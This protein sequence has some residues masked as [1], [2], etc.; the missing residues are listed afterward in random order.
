MLRTLLRTLCGALLA[1]ASLTA[2]HANLVT[3]GG[4][5]DG[6]TGFTSA[7]TY[8]SD[9][10]PEGTYYVGSD[11]HNFHPLFFGL[12]HSGINFM[13]VNGSSTP[14]MRSGGTLLQTRSTRENTM[15][16]SKSFHASCRDRYS[17]CTSS[18][19]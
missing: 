5:E 14:G 3:N 10:W 15:P 13:I 7:Y 9:L 19:R 16:L 17:L 18:Q 6:N 8:Q 1:S 4:F 11:A 2:A 12:P